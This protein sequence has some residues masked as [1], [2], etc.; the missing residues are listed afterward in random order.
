MEARAALE[1]GWVAAEE[2]PVPGEADP[3]AARLRSAARRAHPCHARRH[4]GPRLGGRAAWCQRNARSATRG[5]L[6]TAMVCSLASFAQHPD[7]AHQ[8]ERVQATRSTRSVGCRPERLARRH[9]ERLSSAASAAASGPSTAAPPALS[10]AAAATGC[11]AVPGLAAAPVAAHGE[12][13]A[14]SLPCPGLPRPARSPA[15]LSPCSARVPTTRRALPARPA[16]RDHSASRARIA[17]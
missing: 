7:A 12:R 4:G 14:A 1:E 15:S 8:Q 10:A 3:S 13:A 9:P 11:S 16:V 5:A 6:L 2:S 17:R